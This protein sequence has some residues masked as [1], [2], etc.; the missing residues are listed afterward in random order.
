MTLSWLPTH[1][2]WEDELTR[3]RRLP[4]I[5]A[6]PQ[7]VKLAHYSLDFLQTL[8][9]DRAVQAFEEQAGVCFDK[10]HTVKI[11]LLGS[12]TLTHLVAGIRVAALR[13]GMFVQIY[14]GSY[15]QY[16]QELADTSSGLYAFQPSAVLFALDARH[17]FSGDRSTVEDVF[18]NL[19]PCWQLTREQLGASVIQQTLLPVFN[20]LI[21][22]NEHVYEAS[23]LSKVQDFN[24]RLRRDAQTYGIHLLSVDMMAQA[25]GLASWTDPA[26]WFRSKQ[27]MH[28]RMAP[29]YGDHVARIIA[30][31]RGLSSKCLVL[32]LDNTL[33]GGVIGDDGVEGVLIGQ[34]HAVG[35]AFASFQAYVKRLSRRG[36]ILAVCSKNDMANAL[37]P[38]EQTPEMI[39]KRSDISCFVAN[40][41][42]KATNIRLIAKTLNIGLESIVFVDDN[43]FERSLVREELPM[44]AVPELPDDPALYETVVAAAG[45]FETFNITD[46]DR[47]RIQQYAGNAQRS[48]LR[49]ESTDLAGYLRR[50]DMELTWAP[51]DELNLNRITQLIN[52]SNQFN[53]TTK[54]YTQDEVR[55]IAQ[56]PSILTLRLRLVDSLGDNGTIAIVIARLNRGTTLEIDTWLMSCRVLGRQIEEATLNLIVELARD[57]DVTVIQGTYIATQKNSLVKDLYSRLGFEASN[58][59]NPGHTVWTLS[60]HD[61]VPRTTFATIIPSILQVEGSHEQ[62]S[63]VSA[64]Y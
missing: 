52:K 41:N 33:W 10:A 4:A 1:N 15:G 54:R 9:L 12:S 16:R 45:Y 7:L 30:A 51:F 40:W 62:R 27:E 49:E 37:S 60:T 56:D 53:L 39:L 63:S 26:L 22:N 32:D 44:V 38:F 61:Y 3:V 14:E 24:Q 64:T 50:L 43:P 2:G 6:F 20:S 36:V 57:H 25:D 34:G 35:E 23:P 21:G 17:L 59:D 5:E 47:L 55:A 31:M 46:D 28:P 42:D 13:R 11:A 48:S 58:L 19:I 29:L 8:R 18:E